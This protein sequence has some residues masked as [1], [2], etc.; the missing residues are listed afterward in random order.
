MKLIEEERAKM[1]KKQEKE[2]NDEQLRI[3]NEKDIKEEEIRKQIIKMRD[4]SYDY[5][6]QKGEDQHNLKENLKEKDQFGYFLY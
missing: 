6:N 1:M 5:L 3:L 2:E 4:E